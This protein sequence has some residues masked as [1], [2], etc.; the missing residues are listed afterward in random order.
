M[1]QKITILFFSLVS[2]T[3]IRHGAADIEGTF[4]RRSYM[5]DYHHDY[6]SQ[7]DGNYYYKSLVKF[8]R[9]K[10]M[11]LSRV[12]EV[13][14]DITEHPARRRYQHIFFYARA[15]CKIRIFFG[16]EIIEDN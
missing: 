6:S 3:E 13:P 1:A 12:V 10:K 14:K 4:P 15:I 9:S 2:Q 7:N 5:Y 11:F 16:V 8:A